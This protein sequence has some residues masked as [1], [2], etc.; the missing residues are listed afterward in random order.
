MIPVKFI[1]LEKGTQLKR[2]ECFRPVSDLPYAVIIP[3]MV[4]VVE[5]PMHWLV[6]VVVVV[7]VAGV[8]VVVEVVVVVGVVVVVVGVVGVV[9]S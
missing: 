6:V 8:V 1:L 9:S 7:V 5:A 2:F 3:D 4:L